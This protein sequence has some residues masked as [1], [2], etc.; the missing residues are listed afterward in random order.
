MDS[1]ENKNEAGPLP[2]KRSAVKRLGVPFLSYVSGY[3]SIKRQAA[4]MKHRMSFPMLHQARSRQAE[5]REVAAQKQLV[6]LDELSEQQLSRSRRGHLLILWVMIPAGIWALLTLARGLAALIRF[7]VYLNSWLM[8]G[9]PL[10]IFTVIKIA[11][12]LKAY[13][14]FSGELRARR[15]ANA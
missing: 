7:D 15:C 2:E 11:T 8:T 3:G 12:S 6:M 9:I 5:A 4:I 14:L 13:R 10:T 1:T